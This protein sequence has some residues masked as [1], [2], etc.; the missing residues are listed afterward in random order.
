[1]YLAG[2][3]ST[4]NTAAALRLVKPF[5]IDACSCLEIEKGK[6]DKVKTINFLSNVKWLNQKEFL[7][8]DI[9]DHLKHFRAGDFSY[10][11]P[12]IRE[13]VIFIFG[14][15]CALKEE[16]FKENMKFFEQFEKHLGIK[17]TRLVDGFFSYE[18][19]FLEKSDN[20]EEKAFDLFFALL[21]EFKLEKEDLGNE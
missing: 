16:Q 6:K 21:E 13:I 11:K 10:L 5:A 18:T 12:S 8:D 1:M 9:F 17:R 7:Y 2:G 19:Y 3:L 14:Y 20:D 4:N 15:F